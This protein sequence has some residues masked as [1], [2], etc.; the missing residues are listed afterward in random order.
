MLDSD[1]VEIT[2]FDDANVARI[3]AT[4]TWF[5]QVVRTRLE[6]PG[7]EAWSDERPTRYRVLVR[8]WRTAPDAARPAVKG[9]EPTASWSRVAAVLT[10]FRSVEIGDRELRINGA[11]PLIR[12]AVRHEHSPTRGR[13][14]DPETTWFELCLAKRLNVNAVRTNLR[15]MGRSGGSMT[16]ATSWACTSLTRPTWRATGRQ[17][18]NVH[19]C[20]SG[21]IVQELRMAQ[22]RSH[23]QP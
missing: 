7:I 13:Y 8:L 14:V 6:V 21:A 18:A 9:I 19:R 15:L 17:V 20:S 4:E 3:L 22:Q 2:V 23:H 5:R 12:G 11:V 10:G 16:C 1:P